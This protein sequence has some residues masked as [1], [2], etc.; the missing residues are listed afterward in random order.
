MSFYKPFLSILFFLVFVQLSHSQTA[1]SNNSDNYYIIGTWELLSST[2]SDEIILFR[3]TEGQNLKRRGPLV[4]ISN[5][6]FIELR[7]MVYLGRCG[8]GH[9]GRVLKT[10]WSINTDK[11]IL[12]TKIPI[13][14]DFD[15]YK[16]KELNIKSMVLV[17]N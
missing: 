11:R 5:N 17:K 3:K 8:N 12:K 2:S 9:G 13:I 16:I 10:R 14:K 7:P 4:I 1:M 15:L 6:G